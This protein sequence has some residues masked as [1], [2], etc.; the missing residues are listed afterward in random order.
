M[1]VDDS[2]AVEVLGALRRHGVHIALDDFGTGYSSLGY[3]R[4]LP[5]DGIKIDRSFI[6]GLGAGRE[7]AAIVEAAIS[8]AHALDLSVTAEGIETDVQ[9]E[10]LRGL[11]C[12]LGQGFRFAPPLPSTDLEALLRSGTALDAPRRSTSAA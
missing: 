11:R 7:Q 1:L 8:F 3:L 6:D 12:D 9:L 10:T 5:A 4:S 2:V